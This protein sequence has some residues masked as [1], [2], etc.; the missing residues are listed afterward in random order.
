MA[1]RL[2][3]RGLAPDGLLRP[4]A[5]GARE[6]R[7]LEVHRPGGQCTEARPLPNA[8]RRGHD[9]DRA[10]APARFVN[11]DERDEGSLPRHP[12]EVLR[13]GV[14]DREGAQPLVAQEADV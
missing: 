1:G 10:L 3:D 8:D 5:G 13:R 2:G 6:D 11:H 12:P 9:G 4:G 14:E 7:A